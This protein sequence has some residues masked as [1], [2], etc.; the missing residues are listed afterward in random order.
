MK[1]IIFVILLLSQLLYSIDLDSITEVV[2]RDN[3]AYKKFDTKP[4]TGLGK[5]Y[6]KIG[7]SICD[8]LVNNFKNGKEDAG[9][10]Q[11]W[12]CDGQ[13]KLMFRTK[14][15]NG[16]LIKVGRYESWDEFSGS[17]IE[18]KIYNEKGEVIKDYLKE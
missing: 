12:A 9:E 14:F 1:K 17:K 18:D 6:L 7:D 15:Y 10:Y 13:L 11:I 3:I 5:Y 4:Y 8:I 16:K 2:M